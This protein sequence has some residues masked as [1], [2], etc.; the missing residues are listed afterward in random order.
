MAPLPHAGGGAGKKFPGTGG[1]P[2]KITINGAR[3]FSLSVFVSFIAFIET[4]NAAT[5]VAVF[6]SFCQCFCEIQDGQ[7]RP[8]LTG[9]KLIFDVLVESV[10]APAVA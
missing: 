5:T 10:R 8:H 9:W 1:W 4:V 2:S 3:Y 7:K 6:V